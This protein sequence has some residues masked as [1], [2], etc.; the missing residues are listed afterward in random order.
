MLDES[1]WNDAPEQRPGNGGTLEQTVETQG[2]APALAG[3]GLLQLFLLPVGA[4]G[5]QVAQK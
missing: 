1:R 4:C 2:N 3:H 5:L